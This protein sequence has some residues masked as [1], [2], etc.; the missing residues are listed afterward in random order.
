MGLMDKVKAAAQDAQV[1]AKKATAQGQE[2]L[3]GLKERRK[4]DE[5]AK[6]LGYLIF[7][8]RSEGTPGGS[9]VDRLVGEMKELDEQIR[10]RGPESPNVSAEAGPPVGTAE[11]SGEKQATDEGSGTTASSDEGAGEKTGF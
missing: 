4:M 11:G 1:Q 9:D 2:K 3:E 5:A 6:Q 7:R 8:E 10:S